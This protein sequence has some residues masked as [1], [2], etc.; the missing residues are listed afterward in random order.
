MERVH[1]NIVLCVV[2]S[3]NVV[4]WCISTGHIVESV[5]DIADIGTL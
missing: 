5:D 1:E 2:W 3:G 4:M